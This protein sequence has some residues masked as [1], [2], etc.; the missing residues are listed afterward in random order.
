[1]DNTTDD[2]PPRAQPTAT[3]PIGPAPE[4]PPFSALFPN[5]ERVSTAGFRAGT[6][7][8]RRINRSLVLAGVF[9]VVAGAL[10]VG[11]LVF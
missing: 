11:T 9:V 2:G 1:M 6:L 7:S 10:I 5:L 3:D 4:D 8:R